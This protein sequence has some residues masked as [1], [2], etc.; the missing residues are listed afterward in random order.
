MAG[1]FKLKDGKKLQDFFKSLGANLKRNRK[2]IGGPNKGK[3]QE[4]P[5]RKVM[6]DGSKNRVI[7]KDGV[8]NNFDPHQFRKPKN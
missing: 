2:Y 8:V 3:K 5:G 4:K 7:S 1:P 6:I